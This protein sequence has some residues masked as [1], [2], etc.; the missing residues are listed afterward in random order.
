MREFSLFP[1]LMYVFFLSF[2]VKQDRMAVIY[3]TKL[4]L[5]RWIDVC[6]WIGVLVRNRWNSFQLVGISPWKYLIHN[7]LQWWR[8][9]SFL[10]ELDEAE[11]NVVCH[12]LNPFVH[13]SQGLF[14]VEVIRECLFVQQWN[15]RE[16]EAQRTGLTPRMLS[17][18]SLIGTPWSGDNKKP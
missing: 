5:R 13:N 12:L 7:K 1:E 8:W 17:Y 16:F 2:I 15:W 14:L 3:T 6:P 4:F 10:S 18:H 11:V 9:R